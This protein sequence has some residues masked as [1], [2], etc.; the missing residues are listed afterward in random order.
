MRV[1]VEVEETTIENED[2]REQPGV[3][4]TCTRCHDTA[5]SFGTGEPSVKRACVVLRENCS[6]RERNFYVVPDLSGDGG[7]GGDGGEESWSPF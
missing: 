7:D 1:E 4:V 3:V 5:E 2:G 6:R